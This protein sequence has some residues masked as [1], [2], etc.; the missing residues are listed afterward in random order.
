LIGEAASGADAGLAAAGL[1]VAGLTVFRTDFLEVGS[2]VSA[3]LRAAA[4][5]G[6]STGRSAWES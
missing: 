1:T 4:A 5:T 6:D 2:G 3:P